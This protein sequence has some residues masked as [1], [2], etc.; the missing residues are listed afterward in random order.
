MSTRIHEVIF[1]TT[2][3]PPQ[4]ANN[5][6]RG[7]WHP[8]WVLGSLELK[9]YPRDRLPCRIVLALP[10]SHQGIFVI[11]QLRPQ[12]LHSTFLPIRYYLAT[13]IFVDTDREGWVISGFLLGC[14]AVST[15]EQLQTFRG[16]NIKIV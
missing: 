11:S 12:P 7:L 1:Q 15:G 3:V 6:Y 9:P 16:S 14:Y 5:E 4:H 13:P 10:Q 8:Y 2:D